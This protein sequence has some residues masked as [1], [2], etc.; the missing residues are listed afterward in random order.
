MN[1]GEL[2]AAGRV[3]LYCVDS[4]D[5]SRWHAWGERGDAAYFNNPMD[6]V[7]HDWP[8]WRAQFAHHLPRFC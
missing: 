2:L 5:S 1:V 4:Y 3:K 7:A 6:D 8:S